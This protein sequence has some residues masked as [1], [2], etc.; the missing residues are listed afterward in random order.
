[1]SSAV[2]FIG[3]SGLYDIQGLE[4]VREIEVRTP[5]G[6]PSDV[7]IA[8]ML[9][10]RDIYFLP[11]HGRG[12]RLLPAEINHRANVLAL[13]SLGARWLISVG[14][15]GSLQPHLHPRDIVVPDQFFDR[16]S[17]RGEHTFFGGGIVAH[18]PFA[19]PTS[20]RLRGLLLK[21]AEAEAPRVHDGGTYVNMD[22]PAFSTRAESLF[23]HHAGFAV[24]GMTN[25]PEAK[26]ARE[27]E[28]AYAALSLV[29]DYDAW[30]DSEEAVQVDTLIGHLHANAETARR[31]IARVVPMIPLDAH[32]T[33]HTILDTAILTPRP[34]WPEAKRVELQAILRR[35]E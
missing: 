15:V 21:A 1:M 27:A 7:V 34:H 2:A 35:F 30:S 12:H 13:R 5:Y 3:G 25:L 19:E 6:P 4:G 9:Q 22:G 10:G 14:A 20:L 26:L 23:N 11:R 16:M 28:M 24:V 31:I 17:N 33:E 29:T 18:I 32:E 8:G